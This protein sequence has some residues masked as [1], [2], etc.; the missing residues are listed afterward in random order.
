MNREENFSFK[1]V[2]L[3]KKIKIIKEQELRYNIFYYFI[4]LILIIEFLS[5]DFSKITIYLDIFHEGLWLTASSNSYLNKG[6]WSSSYIARGFYGNFEPFL[7]WKLFNIET[8]GLTRFFNLFLL[9]INKI[10]LVS[11]SREISK[12]LLFN[13]KIKIFYFIV[14]SILL[15]S[16]VGYGGFV[17]GYGDFVHRSFLFL[18]FFLIFFNSLYQA[19][20]LSLPLFLLGIFS[21]ISLLWYIDIGAYINAL[22]LLILTFFLAR[23]EFKKFLSILLGVILGWSIFIFTVPTHEL[24][25]FFHNTLSIYATID[26]IQGLIYPTP[27]LSGDT[28][29][30]K[31]LLLII[32]SG[33]F[34][35]I[36]NFNKKIN[37]SY[38]NKIFLLFIFAASLLVFKTGL[39]RSDAP[40]IKA[41]SGFTLFL[42]Y[43]IGLYFLINF[44]INQN[45]VNKIILKLKLFFKKEYVNLFLIFIFL[46]FSILKE[47]LVNIKNI[48]SSMSK[49]NKLINYDDEKYLST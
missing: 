14:L 4:I 42:I 29:S 24:N 40:H 48:P 1:E 12:N 35:I 38:Y 10:L 3:D 31:A 9:L 43:S 22:L 30:T 23:F 46:N 18:L 25:E 36:I 17:R 28:R 34:V 33:I 7:L 49:I 45:K 47:N 16:L 13:E 27:F 21:V 41:S 44:L 37:L 2:I 5:I 11:L 15:I 39:S 20:K 26:Y 19:D 8:I 32:L 6:F